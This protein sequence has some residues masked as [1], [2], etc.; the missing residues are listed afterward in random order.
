[1]TDIVSKEDVVIL[2]NAFYER[3]LQDDVLGPFFKHVNFE[4]HKPKMIH[5]WSF[6]LLDEPGYTTNITEV[7]QHLHANMQ[8]YMHWND[9][10]SETVNAH[11]T[12]P[13]AEAAKLRAHT[14]AWTMG[15]K[16]NTP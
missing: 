16:F 13:N 5:F 6:V 7:H 9:L 1:M 10:F 15:T 11:F 12:G 14:L 4:K 3:V 2:V 8:A